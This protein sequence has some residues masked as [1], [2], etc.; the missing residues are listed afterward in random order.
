MGRNKFKLKHEQFANNLYRLK[1]LKNINNLFRFGNYQVDY[2][3]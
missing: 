2:C 3:T 1:A